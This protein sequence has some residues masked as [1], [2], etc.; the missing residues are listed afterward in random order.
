MPGGINRTHAFVLFY[1]AS[2]LLYCLFWSGTSGLK[3]SFCFV[4]F[5]VVVLCRC[6]IIFS[7]VSVPKTL[8]LV[9]FIFLMFVSCC[10]FGNVKRQNLVLLLLGVFC[11]PYKY[12][13]VNHSR[14]LFLFP[15]MPAIK[16]SFCFGFVSFFQEWQEMRT[17]MVER[18]EKEE[19]L[20]LASEARERRAIF[21]A[22]QPIRRSG[23]LSVSRGR[24]K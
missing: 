12:R 4:L 22:E 24:R 8:L 18:M 14:F 20:R 19:K 13:Q 3:P 5:T 7:E 9:S 2:C 6:S 1:V 10:I 23:R 16:P 15:G 17:W 21:I 11:L